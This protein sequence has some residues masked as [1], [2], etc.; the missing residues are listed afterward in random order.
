M[1]ERIRLQRTKGWR[2]PEGAVV[3][4][5]PS[6]WG[7]P[8]RA[9]PTAEGWSVF[10]RVKLGSGHLDVWIERVGIVT[11]AEAVAE[12]V[13][14]FRKWVEAW[15]EDEYGDEPNPVGYALEELRGRDLACWCPLT[16]DDGNRVP[17]HA[18][19]LI[20]LANAPAVEVLDEDDGAGL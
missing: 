13:R 20:A 17:C 18:D 4:S 11:R 9:M 8:Y 6:R 3:V 2:L 1:P 14:L 12:S 16:D 19:A 5:R 10:S 7:N 15:A